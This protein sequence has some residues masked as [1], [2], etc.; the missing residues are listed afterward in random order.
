M[1]YRIVIAD[2]EALICMDLKEILEEAGHTVVGMAS[3]GV[4]AVE[5]VYAKRPDIVFLDV[6]MPRLDGIRAARMIHRNAAAPVILLTAYGRKEVVEEAAGSGVYGY[7]V[8]PVNPDNLFPA[9]EVAAAQFK[10]QLAHEREVAELQ[11]EIETRKAV[12]R[13]KGILMDTC[14]VSEAEAYKRL[15]QYSMKKGI[16]LKNVALGLIKATVH[17]NKK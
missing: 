9:M 15:Q 7:L 6:K 12:E 1:A 5:L 2:D 10:R 8:K 16:P 17:K 3:D 4:E 11:D 14:S 13:A